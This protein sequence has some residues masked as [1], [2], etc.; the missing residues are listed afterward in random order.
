MY[1]IVYNNNNKKE[2]NADGSVHAVN[3]LNNSG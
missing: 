2:T 1:F 3:Q